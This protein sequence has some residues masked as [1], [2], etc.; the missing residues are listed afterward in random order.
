MPRYSDDPVYPTISNNIS[1]LCT[2]IIGNK[3]T[4]ADS[5]KKDLRQMIQLCDVDL[6]AEYMPLNPDLPPELI[7]S[8]AALYTLPEVVQFLYDNGL[9]AREPT[10]PDTIPPL[11]CVDFEKKTALATVKLMVANGHK[12]NK[13]DPKNALWKASIQGNVEVTNYFIDQGVKLK[14]FGKV[15]KDNFECFKICVERKALKLE[16]DCVYAKEAFEADFDELLEFCI[17]HGAVLDPLY[18]ATAVFWKQTSMVRLLLENGCDPN[19]PGPMEMTP[20]FQAHAKHITKLLLDHGANPN[21]VSVNGNTALEF[22]WNCGGHGH[23]RN[24]WI[25]AYSKGSQSLRTDDP[26]TMLSTT[27]RLKILNESDLPINPSTDF[28]KTVFKA[29]INTQFASV[30][31]NM[32]LVRCRN[33]A[34]LKKFRNKTIAERQRCVL[35]YKH[36]WAKIP[37]FDPNLMELITAYI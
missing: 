4:L 19:Y 17:K 7:L 14:K 10:N 1:V 35:A 18:L 21:Y 29:K 13:K 22:N 25:V 32:E 31:W 24:K 5:L 11:F 33:V 16:K 27:D 6:S 15:T 20:I 37:G 9:E 3:R 26:F 2:A 28:L 12:P 23:E 34:Y 30:L 36:K 8:C